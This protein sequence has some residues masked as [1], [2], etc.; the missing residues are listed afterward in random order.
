MDPHF[1]S[2]RRRA[3]AGLRVPA[4]WEG[5]VP[6]EEASFFPSEASPPHAPEPTRVLSQGHHCIRYPLSPRVARVFLP[7]GTLQATYKCL[8][9][10]TNSDQRPP[11]TQ[12]TIC[13]VKVTSDLQEVAKS[14]GCFSFVILPEGTATLDG[15]VCSHLH[16]CPLT[17]T[18]THTC[19]HALTH[20][21]LASV[22]PDVPPT[23]LAALP[24]HVDSIAL[25]CPP[26]KC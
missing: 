23:S 12:S 10:P 1:S 16:T 26:P 11:P 7:L 21:V 15:E 8:P 2:L 24:G 3:N 13:F 6:E 22:I 9:S 18:H 20:S 5:L 14:K 19:T 4:A 25:L 17:L